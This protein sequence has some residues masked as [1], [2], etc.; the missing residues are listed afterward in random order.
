MWRSGSIFLWRLGWGIGQGCF[1]PPTQE[2][3]LDRFLTELHAERMCARIRSSFQC[4]VTTLRQPFGLF[5]AQLKSSPTTQKCTKKILEE[6][7]RNKGGCTSERSSGGIGNSASSWK[8]RPGSKLDNWAAKPFCHC[9]R[10]PT[11]IF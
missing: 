8:Q 9:C 2:P 4:C 5:L 1:Q 3:H 10:R 6:R 7:I 11:S